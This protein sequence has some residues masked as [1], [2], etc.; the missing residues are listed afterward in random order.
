M[1]NL[2]KKEAV[3]K[4]VGEFNTI[5]SS[6]IEKAYP[7]YDGFDEITPK[8]IEEGTL[9]EYNGFDFELKQCY[10]LEVIIVDDDMLT[11]K[12][13]DE[14]DVE[15]HGEEIEVERSECDWEDDSYRDGWLPMWGWLWTVDSY[16]ESWIRNNLERAS[17][18]GFRIYEDEEG[19]IYIGID[20]AGYDFYSAH[21]EPLYDAM[22]LKWHN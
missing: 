19:D 18:I 22:G 20:G 12:L 5:K 11:L 4:M 9:V 6:L 2:T 3:Q 10:D 15:E 8:H 17:D 7:Y 13:T 21:W 14:E 16:T 1:K